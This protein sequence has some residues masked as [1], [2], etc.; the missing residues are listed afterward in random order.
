MNHVIHRAL[1]CLLIMAGLSACAVI[2]PQ[3]ANT[4]RIIMPRCALERNADGTACV[5]HIFDGNALQAVQQDPQGRSFIE[6]PIDSV[7]GPRVAVFQA[8]GYEPQVHALKMIVAESDRV[9]L[10]RQGDMRGGMLAGII[11]KPEAETMEKGVCGIENFLAG[12]EV[13]V[14]RGRARYTAMT[15]SIGSFVL[16]LP[17]GDYDVRVEG[18]GREVVVPQNDTLFMTLPI[19]GS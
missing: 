4:A 14:H 16:E 8:P 10:K 18:V 9:E 7:T 1:A 15:D 5:T 19:L 11:F 3:L 12:R 13:I 2:N 6:V 17:A